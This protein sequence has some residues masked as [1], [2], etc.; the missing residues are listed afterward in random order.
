MP[1]LPGQAAVSGPELLPD[2]LARAN[3]KRSKVR[4]AVEH[5][6]AR[7]K[8]NMGLIVRTIGLNLPFDFFEIA[9][10]VYDAKGQ[11][12]RKDGIKVR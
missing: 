11:L 4:A 7:Q 10:T 2:N 3:A 1:E 5:V 8:H 9:S 6:F 12:V